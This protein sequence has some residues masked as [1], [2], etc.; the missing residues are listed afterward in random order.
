MIPNADQFINAYFKTEENNPPILPDLVR[1]IAADL[2]DGETPFS[3]AQLEKEIEVWISAF[4]SSNTIQ[5]S[6]TLTPRLTQEYHIPVSTLFNAAA[7]LV[8]TLTE[9]DA[10]MEY[11]RKTLTAEQ[12]DTYL[13]P[14]LAY[15]YLDAMKNL[16]L[17]GD[18]IFTKTVSALGE[19]IESSLTL[20]LDGKKTG[21]SSVTFESDETRKSFL[22]SGKKGIFYLNLPIGFD[23]KADAYDE[24]I[25]LA[26]VNG[27]NP[28]G[29][30]LALLIRASKEHDKYDDADDS[31][32]HEEDHY[33]IHIEK[34]TSGLPG[35]IGEELI[36]DMEPADAKID[37]HYYSKLQLSSPT[38]LEISCEIRQGGYEFSLA[39]KL[40]SASWW[41]FAPFDI[42]GAID[43][44]RYSREDFRKLK[45]QWIKNADQKLERTPEEISLAETPGE[46]TNPEEIPEITGTEDPDEPSGG[47]DAAE[48][49]DSTV[50]DEPEE[51]AGPSEG[52]DAAEPDGVPEGTEL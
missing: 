1:I 32:N 42:A 11:F 44:V 20:P 10:A 21:F 45:D 49:I 19:T 36:P 29:R 13:N 30:N 18:I 50:G 37:L 41:I 16:N 27:S 4:K 39:G 46:S 24:T 14:D 51:S 8:R 34:D 25:R 48:P 7:N 43:A 9:D 52:E 6:E 35:I 31:R 22:L 38:I 12:I 40:K 3:T 47:D 5:S 17:E 33:T 15:Y 26:Y 2:K 23:F 28:D